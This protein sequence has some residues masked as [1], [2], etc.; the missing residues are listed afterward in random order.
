MNIGLLGFGTVGSAFYALA[1]E[2]ADIGISRLLVLEP[3]PQAACAQTTDFNEILRDESIDTVVE[4]IGGLHPAYEFVSAALR[5]GKNVA[6]ANKWLVSAY[7][8]ELIDLAQAN[9]VALRCTAAAGG[10][11]PWLH[12]LARL[13]AIDSVSAVY[14]IM[15][16]S[17]NYMLSAMTEQGVDY[18]QCMR[19]AKRL[20]Y[21]EADPTADVEGYDARRKLVLSANIAFGVSIREEEVPC[22]GISGIEQQDIAAFK[23]MGLVC[24][25]I[26]HAERRGGAVSACVEP[27]LFPVS[28]QMAH[29]NGADNLISLTA[30]R[31]GRQS[32]AGAGAGG[33]ATASNVLADCLEIQG[34]CAPFYTLQ[35]TPAAVCNDEAAQ[36]YYVRTAEGA[37]A[38]ALTVAQAC[39]LAGEYRQK[40]LPCFV[41]AIAEGE[42]IC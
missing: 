13:R 32:F 30:A 3:L 26:A 14:G 29:I 11:I 18:A 9:G 33:F 24:K 27:M 19:E 35:K 37:Q 31:V 38:R 4:L 6:T 40:G 21:L 25:L 10:G 41:A 20:G 15:N 17:T 23:R 1:Q 42:S 5:A 2:R 8:N 34:G 16:G 7:Y 28:G 12:S 22:I 36:R 39:R